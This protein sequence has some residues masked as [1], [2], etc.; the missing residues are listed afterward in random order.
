[1]QNIPR[2]QYDRKEECFKRV[3]SKSPPVF[4]DWFRERFT[5]PHNW[6]QA[7]NAYVRTTAVMSIVG[8]I[9]GLGDRHGENILFDGCTGD[10]VHVDFNCLFNKGETFEVP[11][12][13]PFRL[14]HNMVHAMGPLGIEG[15]YRM[16]CEITLKVLQ[17]QMTTLMCVLRPFVYDPL[18]TWSR[19]SRNDGQV[20]RTDSQ[21][22]TNVEHI[23]QRL[24]GYV[25]RTKHNACTYVLI[26]ILVSIASF[27]VKINQINSNMPLSAEGVVNHCILES[28][29]IKNLSR[30]Y[31]GWG[32]YL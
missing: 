29:D 1:M 7:R 2:G 8:Y 3:L 21:A 9:L 32:A 5:T 18:V 14:T 13:V 6:F 19:L 27:Q 23:E 11:E 30:M 25:R 24:K 12:I 22:M 10:I 31:V 15:P 26:L 28:I 4:S 20:E 16:C 17:E